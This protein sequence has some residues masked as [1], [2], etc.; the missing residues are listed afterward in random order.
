MPMLS[1]EKAREMLRGYPFRRGRSELEK[2]FAALFSQDEPCI[3]TTVDGLQ[4]VLPDYRRNARLFWS[5]EESEPALQFYVRRFVPTGGRV[6]EV[7]AASGI[8][9]LLA[10]R[11]KGAHVKLLEVDATLLAT[12]EATLQLNPETA[13]LCELIARPCATTASSRQSIPPGITL[14]EI[15]DDVRWPSVDLVRIGGTGFDALAS[16]GRFLRPDFVEA[17]YIETANAEPSDILKIIDLG[18]AAYETKRESMADLRKL[19]VNQTERHHYH[20]LDLSALAKAAMPANTLF[21]GQQSPVNQH[22][23]RWCI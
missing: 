20:P 1:T 13:S 11:L 5:F 8:I 4:L 18:Y 19:G 14:E 21:L 3:V 7:D 17:I 16:A 2:A 12:L 22:F 10:A 9:G 23:M 15:I 6:I